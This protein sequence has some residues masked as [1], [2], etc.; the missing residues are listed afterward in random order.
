MAGR[1]GYFKH[2]VSG[3]ICYES[4]FTV[5][6]FCI[7]AEV[8]MRHTARSSRKALSLNAMWRTYAYW[9][10]CR[11]PWSHVFSYDKRHGVIDIGHYCSQDPACL[12]HSLVCAS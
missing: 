10:C 12:L 4:P 2:D 9:L 1:L 5:M 7:H 11:A 6:R 3:Q 8:N